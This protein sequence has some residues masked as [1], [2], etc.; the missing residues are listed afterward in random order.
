MFNFDYPLRIGLE[1]THLCNYRCM[2]CYNNKLLGKNKDSFT[3][4]EIEIFLDSIRG[5]V[6]EIVIG[7]GEPLMRKD[8]PYIV[9]KYNNFFKFYITS[10]GSL[11]NKDLLKNFSH[12]IVFQISID[13]LEKTHNFIRNRQTAYV[14]SIRA[15]KLL[16][17]EGY[18]FSAGVMIGKLNISEMQELIEALKNE[19]VDNF[20]FLTY[21]GDSDKLKLNRGDFLKLNKFLNK[22]YVKKTLRDPIFDCSTGECQAG[23]TTINIRADGTV[24]PCCYLPTV[25]G[26]VKERELKDIWLDR[27]FEKIRNKMIPGTCSGCGI[28]LKC[29]GG[30]LARRKNYN[31]KDNL[32]FRNF[33]NY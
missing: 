10:N 1:V 2:H 23:I 12:N 17:S 4:E 6:F 7:G 19:G 18:K 32:C 29:R 28:E 27:K 26:N 20:N 21:I 9:K 14:E 15:M 16:R 5:K 8:L 25:I 31:E 11:L 30:C 22:I 33:T 13:G 24:T 3:T